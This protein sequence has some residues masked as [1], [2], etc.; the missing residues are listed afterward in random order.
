MNSIIQHIPGVCQSSC[1]A[2]SGCDALI[3]SLALEV[4]PA[5]CKHHGNIGWACI[6]ARGLA[7]ELARTFAAY[8]LTLCSVNIGG[9]PQCKCD[10]EVACVL[11]CEFQ[12]PFTPVTPVILNWH[13]LNWHALMNLNMTGSYPDP[14][15]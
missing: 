7:A 14:D 10:C 1:G 5:T 11:C 15:P 12:I 2:L 3:T 9:R 8:R 4:P 6:D 13:E